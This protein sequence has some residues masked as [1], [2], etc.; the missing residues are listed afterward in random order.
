MEVELG[1]KELLKSRRHVHLKK[2][3]TSIAR[4][5]HL[6]SNHAGGQ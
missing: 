1:K 4:P 6:R 5:F 3:I 2:T